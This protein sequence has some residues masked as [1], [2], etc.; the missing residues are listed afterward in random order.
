MRSLIKY[1]IKRDGR[2]VLYVVLT[3][4]ILIFLAGIIIYPNQEKRRLI[5]QYISIL[6]GLLY[7]FNRQIIHLTNDTLFDNK[8]HM[9]LIPKSILQIVMA[10]AI[11]SYFYCIIF[12]SI[13]VHLSNVNFTL[14]IIRGIVYVNISFLIYIILLYL[15]LLSSKIIKK[16]MLVTNL[17]ILLIFS[18]LIFRMLNNILALY[19]SGTILST[20]III[21]LEFIGIMVISSSLGHRFNKKRYI[22]LLIIIT[23]LCVV[24]LTLLINSYNHR[25]I[26]D[27]DLPFIEDTQIIGKWQSIDFVNDFEGYIPSVSS[28]KLFIGDLTFNNDGIVNGIHK[29]KWTKG[30]VMEFPYQQTKSKY[31]IKEINGEQYLF[32]QWKSGNYVF[33][34]TEPSFYVFKKAN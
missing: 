27:I 4:I 21:L 11:V 31:I 1:E 2:K 10:N 12:V 24:F 17:I 25:I 19:L 18:F 15:Y 8:G 5:F 20:I 26:E 13:L 34:H 28:K 32:I 30:F 29:Y 23:S 33:R 9:M 22:P 6:V 16:R 14:K 3:V 7:V